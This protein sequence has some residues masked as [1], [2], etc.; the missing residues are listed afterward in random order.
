MFELQSIFLFLFGTL[1]GTFGTMLGV[2]GGWAHVPFLLLL[3]NFSPQSAI[4]T[5]LGIIF[6]NTLAGSLV[7]FHQKQ[8]D[9]ALAK[10]LSWAVLPGAIIGPFVVQ[11]YTASFF[12]IIFAFLLLLLSAYCFVQEKSL[13]IL[14]ESKYNRIVTI[15]DAFG[16][17]TTYATNFEIGFIGTL[18]IGFLSNLFGIGG[19]IIH[20]PFFTK[21]LR[22][23][24]HIALGT[25]HLI[26]CIS[27]GVGFLIY[28]YMGYV[29]FDFMM[30][31]ALG[32]IIGARIGAAMSQKMAP[33]IIHRIIAAILF[34]VAMKMFITAVG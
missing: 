19:G 17:K 16:N 14:P 1:V 11:H 4:A 22:M 30:P 32:A 23:P 7:Y 3:Y 31:I 12:M 33:A 9:F 28:F 13:R 8:M 10:K 15:T 26:L 5:S 6:L 27:S 25:S 18:G 20:V 29:V 21:I 2:G 34:L 24:T